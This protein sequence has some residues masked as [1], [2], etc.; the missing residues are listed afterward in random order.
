MMR[1]ALATL[2]MVAALCGGFGGGVLWEL[3]HLPSAP[4]TAQAAT[5]RA[6]VC[7]G[8]QVRQYAVPSYACGWVAETPTPAP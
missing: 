2:G 1:R 4:E 6:W 5:P 3:H 7:V 8:S